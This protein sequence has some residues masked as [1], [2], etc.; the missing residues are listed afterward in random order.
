MLAIRP[1][2]CVEITIN[3]TT[4][5]KRTCCLTSHGATVTN[6]SNSPCMKNRTCPADAR[7]E[8]KN[9]LESKTNRPRLAANPRS[10]TRIHRLQRGSATSPCESTTTVNQ[11]SNPTWI[12][13]ESTINPTTNRSTDQE[14][15]NK[16]NPTNDSRQRMRIGEASRGPGQAVARGRGLAAGCTAAVWGLP[17]WVVEGTA[18]DARLDGSCRRPC[19]ALLPTGRQGS[20][21]LLLHERSHCQI[22]AG[23]D[24]RREGGGWRGCRRLGGGDGGCC[25]EE[26][27]EAQAGVAYIDWINGSN[28]FNP[29]IM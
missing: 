11:Q 7:L 10:S 21:L 13:C 1:Y 29:L 3:T 25:R 23:W 2:L 6:K 26:S 17:R 27:G 4:V 5:T 22:H 20:L 24:R 8:K 16:S 14:Q 28:F 12:P 9:S 15:I 18:V 19:A